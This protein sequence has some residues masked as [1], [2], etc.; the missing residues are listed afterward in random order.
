MA[1]AKIST[2]LKTKYGTIQYRIERREQPDP[3]NRR[4]TLKA[5]WLYED[6]KLV[7]HYQCFGESVYQM[8]IRAGKLTDPNVF[9]LTP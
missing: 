8:L 9:Q 6:N 2:A 3:V 1:N 7:D 4:R 5:Y